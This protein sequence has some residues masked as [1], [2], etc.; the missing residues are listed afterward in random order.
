MVKN[1]NKI[2]LLILIKE[3]LDEVIKNPFNSSLYLLNK[4]SQAAILDPF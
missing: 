2:I 1:T 4:I 3:F